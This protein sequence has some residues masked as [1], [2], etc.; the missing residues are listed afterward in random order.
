METAVTDGKTDDTYIPQTPKE[1]VELFLKRKALFFLSFFNVLLVAAVV[2]PFLPKAYEASTLLSVDDQSLLGSAVRGLSLQE[3]REKSLKLM[4]MQIMSFPNMRAVGKKIGWD[5]SDPL[6][7]DGKV[8]KMAKRVKV[9]MVSEGLLQISYRDKDRAEARKVADL[10]AAQ[11]VESNRQVKMGE[12]ETAIQFIDQQLRIYKERL[13]NSEQSF[14]LAKSNTELEALQQQRRLLAEQLE[15]AEKAAPQDPRRGNPLTFELRKELVLAENQLQQLLLTA[16]KEHPIM[17]ELRQKVAMLRKRLQLEKDSGS[18]A[19]AS[20]SSTQVRDLAAKLKALDAQI[21]TVRG[22]Q[23]DLKGG[24]VDLK[25][26]SEAEL[27][28]MQRDKA[29]NEDIYRSL[30]TRLENAQM[31][32]RLDAVGQG[33]SYKIVEPA[34]LPLRPASPDPLKTGVVVFGLALMAG[35][36]AV[37][38]RE[39]TDSSFRGVRDAKGYL[40]MPLLAY[41]PEIHSPQNGERPSSEFAYVA[42]L[43]KDPD[44]APQIVTF[45]DPNSIPAEQYRLLRTH[46]MF[47][48]EKHPLRTVMITSALEGEGK[49]TTAVNLAISM[50]HELNRKVLLVD[51]D[52]RKGGVEKS[53]GLPRGKGLSHYLSDACSAD[54]VFRKTKVERLTVVTAGDGAAHSPTKLLSSEKMARFVES[55][56]SSHDFV[57]LDAPPVLYLA[58]VPVLTQLA[59]GILL[60]VQIG[61]T[62]RELAGTAL[63]TLEQTRRAN[64]LGAVLTR[65]ERS[66]PAYIQHYLEGG[67]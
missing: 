60:V 55:A 29:V 28:A 47:M 32:Q 12:A 40:K 45:H 33:A 50:A 56:K 54:A 66:V 42:N 62:P 21:G 38:L 7:F 25:G 53:L 3:A 8:S 11:V 16:K 61:K 23:E 49:T 34:R 17:E 2:Y 36:G 59:D 65:V 15:L 19:D 63:A 57:I 5:E 4:T 14:L 43:I 26:V 6:A 37:A 1:Y 30:L 35:V 20:A 41:I 44:I 31:S 10:I 22:R 39:Y 58:D 18:L 24:K 13:R 64:T 67:N 48:S 27:L 9:V 51:C 52:L 46:L